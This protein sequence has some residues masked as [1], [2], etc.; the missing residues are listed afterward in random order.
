MSATQ[1]AARN[2]P[3]GTAIPGGTAAPPFP[4]SLFGL[5]P[6]AVRLLPDEDRSWAIWPRGCPRVELATNWDRSS[7]R[8]PLVLKG[9]RGERVS[10]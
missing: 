7:E 3:F 8:E 2:R 6:G 5:A 1:G 4:T 10:F 9:R